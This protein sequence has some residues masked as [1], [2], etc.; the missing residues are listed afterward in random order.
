MKTVKLVFSIIAL[1]AIAGCNEERVYKPFVQSSF[2][3][4]GCKFTYVKFSPQGSYN[5][6]LWV[7]KCKS[8]EDVA[9]EYKTISGKT[10]ISNN[11]I[12]QMEKPKKKVVQ[13]AVIDNGSTAINADGKSSITIS[14]NGNIIEVEGKK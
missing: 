3:F 10:T 13:E 14:V 4:D 9:V 12:T 5:D 7:A 1:L 6:G 2:E 11:V 8:N